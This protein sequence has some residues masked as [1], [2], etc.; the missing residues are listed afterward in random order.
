M[1]AHIEGYGEIYFL[2]QCLYLTNINLIF[3]EKWIFWQKLLLMH[4][5][6]RRG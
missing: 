4:R 3:E 2:N 5:K 1:V 6:T